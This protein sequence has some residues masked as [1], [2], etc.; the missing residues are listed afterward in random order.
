MRIQSV[1]YYHVRM[2]LRFPF[3]T[4]T[5][6]RTER[7]AL[8]LEVRDAD[9]YV[10]WGEVVAGY[11]PHYSCETAWTAEHI[12][13]EFLIPAL[14]DAPVDHPGDFTDR[15]QWVRGHRM[16]RAGLEMAL[17]DLYGK[18][19]GRSLRDLLGGVRDRVP[20]GV[21]IGLQENPRALV[22]RV[23]YY[24]NQG[25]RR[26]KLKIKPGYD[27]EFV[28]AVR[29]AYPDIPLQVDANSAYDLDTAQTLR[30]L[31]DYQLLLIEQPLAHDDLWDHH[32][33]QQVF[34]TPICLDESITS[35]DKARKAIEMD[36]ARVINIKVGRVGGLIEAVRIHDL[37]A[38][39][40]V[41]VWS[42]GMLE[43]GIGRA[44]NLALASL[45]N[46]RLPSDISATDR[47][48]EMDIT[49]E[50]FALNDDSTITVPLGPGLG[51][52]VNRDALAYY[53][54]HSMTFLNPNEGHPR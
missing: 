8:I 23:G 28:R 12:L 24:L 51:V 25:Y 9:G 42:G 27:V 49:E 13:G 41:P 16:A 34:R 5:A 4:S 32:K 40:D 21:S 52:R 43:T 44:A 47:Y 1:T 10:G 7:D 3:A 53:T 18:R 19:L 30:P 6:S 29:E 37:A 26:I 50:R 46:F 38:Q 22:E 36:A 15:V 45:P 54:L 31:D 11:A 14:F 20:V 17:W 48:Y 35:A 39:H 33:L 2:P